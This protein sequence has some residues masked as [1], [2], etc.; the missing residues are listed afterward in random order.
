[1]VAPISATANAA[2][3][4]R[5]Q[6]SKDEAPFSEVLLLLPP[7]L[8]SCWFWFWFWFCCCVGKGGLE[9]LRAA[10]QSTSESITVKASN[11][12][13][14]SK[15]EEG[16]EICCCEAVPVLVLEV[17][18]TAAAVAAAAA[19]A[20]AVAAAVVDGW[21]RLKATRAVKS[22]TRGRLPTRS[23]TAAAG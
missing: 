16:G 8:V 4:T 12:A 22:G 2:V 3:D 18:A 23:A 19:A 10:N 15:C 17:A 13:D 5:V 20:A 14:A 6:H 21:R 1:M 11:G 7:P 9:S